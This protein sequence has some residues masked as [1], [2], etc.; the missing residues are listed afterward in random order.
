M[1]N[2][3]FAKM[4]TYLRNGNHESLYTDWD[5]RENQEEEKQESEEPTAAHEAS[6]QETDTRA[7]DDASTNNTKCED[8]NELSGEDGPVEEPTSEPSDA[9]MSP[10]EKKDA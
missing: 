3:V 9:K 7:L 2:V 6:T 10:Q 4:D 1:V 5:S 8:A